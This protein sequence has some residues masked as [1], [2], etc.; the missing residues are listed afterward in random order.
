MV[1]RLERGAWSMNTTVKRRSNGKVSNKRVYT[2]PSPP[3]TSRAGDAAIWLDFFRLEGC[4]APYPLPRVGRSGD[5]EVQL[6]V[7]S[8]FGVFL[9]APCSFSS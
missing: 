1:L 7:K 2:P 8:S 5:V 3:P 9:V 4:V 6:L